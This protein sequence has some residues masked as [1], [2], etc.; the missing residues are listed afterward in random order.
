VVLA[1]P[2]IRTAEVDERR[3]TIPW[4]MARPKLAMARMIF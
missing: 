4:A 2:T 1:T 3:A